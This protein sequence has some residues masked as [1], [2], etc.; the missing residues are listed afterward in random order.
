MINCSTVLFVFHFSYGINVVSSSID[1]FNSSM[2]VRISSG[3]DT[4]QEPSRFLFFDSTRNVVAGNDLRSQ[5]QV[6]DLLWSAGIFETVFRRFASSFAA[7]CV[8]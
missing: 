3:D 8:L 7:V 2:S 5:E 4:V 1:A 6:Q